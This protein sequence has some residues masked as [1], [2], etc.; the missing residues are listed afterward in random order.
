MFQELLGIWGAKLGSF[1]EVVEQILLLLLVGGWRRCEQL[2]QTLNLLRR[3]HRGFQTQGIRTLLYGVEELGERLL[4]KMILADA[5]L[6]RD[7][8][9]T[10]TSLV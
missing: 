5:S 10:L 3:K 2:M 9:Q 6:A 1:A 7:T 8:I 4:Y